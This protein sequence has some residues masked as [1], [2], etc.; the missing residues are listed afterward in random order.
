MSLKT[1][2]KNYSSC[3]KAKAPYDD[4]HVKKKDEKLSKA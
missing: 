3:Y 1:W 4:V 2:M